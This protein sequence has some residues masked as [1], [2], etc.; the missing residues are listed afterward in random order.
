M[1]DFKLYRGQVACEV[2]DTF[3]VGHLCISQEADLDSQMFPLVMQFVEH[4]VYSEWSV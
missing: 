4:T 3:G 2:G 1:F